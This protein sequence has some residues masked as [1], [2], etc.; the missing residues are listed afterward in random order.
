MTNKFGDS[1]WSSGRS[2][3]TRQLG[4]GCVVVILAGLAL[5]GWL[6]WRLL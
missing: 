1:E 4:C 2:E 5:V 6:A 3:A